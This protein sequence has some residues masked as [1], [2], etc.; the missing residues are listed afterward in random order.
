MALDPVVNF[1]R[2]TIATLP[3]ASGGTSIVITTGDGAKLPDPAVD[4][5]FNLTIYNEDDPFDAPEIVRVTA[6]AGDTLTVTRAQEGTS[7]T[8]KTSGNTWYLELTPT[9][10]TIQDIDTAKLDVAGG[11][12]TGD[13]T[14]P[15][16]IIH[17]GDTNTAIRFPANDTVSIETAGSEALRV[18]SSQ[19]VGIG[20][21]SPNSK[22][23]INSKT[24]GRPTFNEAIAD[25]LI[26]STG[27]GMSQ[28]FEFYPAISFRTGDPEIDADKRIAFSI[29]AVATDTQ[30]SGL[31]N[32]S[33]LLFMSGKGVS[34]PFEVMR[35]TSAGNVGIG[36]TSP[37]TKLDVNGDV[38]IT[39]KI[40]HS[41]DTNTAIR[42]P[43]ADTV[44][45]ET[46]GVEALR[47]DSSQN[48]GIGTTP[49]PWTTNFNIQALQITN[50][51]VYGATTD[52]NVLQNVYF[53]GTNFIYKTTNPASSY[54]Q[55]QDNHVWKNAPSGTAGTTATLVE[56][57]RI[58]S[59]GNVGIGM[60]PVTKL[61]VTGAIRASTGILF[62]ADTAAANTLDDYEE[63]T[64]T[65]TV[66]GDTTAGTYT[67]T[68]TTANYVK[69]GKVVTLRAQINFSVATGGAGALII[70]NLPFNYMANSNIVGAV[71]VRYLNTPT[72]TSNGLTISNATGSSSTTLYLA[73]N[74]D[75]ALPETVLIDA[76]GASPSTRITFT[77]VY[78][79]T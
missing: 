3:V 25:G 64:W 60:T 33:D 52:F 56:R 47:V 35:I 6:I 43:S 61:D 7:A 31:K 59:A 1:F 49:S 21:T 40:I 70:G 12:M 37:A 42:F 74:L 2:S 73:F 53:N 15:D 19:R 63:G 79:V 9:A 10:K 23:E 17:S 13:L 66:Y 67:T 46:A 16:K 75:N 26:L 45:V 41:G 38:T 29:G 34:T 11:T 8:N 44:T 62:G 24:L 39:D 28:S 30:N 77:I 65:P 20:T 4:G 48:V 14:I 22:I 51:A 36:T 50:G 54:Q 32:D 5:N 78:E 58:T 68:S 71:T 76:V 69:I 27:G 55:T 72:G 57:M 18:D